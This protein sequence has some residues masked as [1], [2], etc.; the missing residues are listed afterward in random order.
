MNLWVI[1][2]SRLV[3]HASIFCY[4]STCR[5]SR[6]NNAFVSTKSPCWSCRILRVWGT[7]ELFQS[8]YASFEVTSI[9]LLEEQQGTISGRGPLYLLLF[10]LSQCLLPVTILYNILYISGNRPNTTTKVVTKASLSWLLLASEV[11]P[12]TE[13]HRA[14]SWLT[15]SPLRFGKKKPVQVNAV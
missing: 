7:F 13:L 11:K 8:S 5:M 3:L 10:A 4:R 14:H 1:C 6:I 9:E 15:A 12:V 2:L